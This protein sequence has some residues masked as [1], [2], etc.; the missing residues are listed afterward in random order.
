MINLSR[1]FP[2]LLASSIVAVSTAGATETPSVVEK[3]PLR[4]ALVESKDKNKGV[5]V[6]AKGSTIALVVTAIDDRYVMGRNQQ[7]TRIVIRI[8]N[9]DGVAG[10]F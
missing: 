6:Y 2:L 9:I 3:D 10:A 4:A 8:D 1:L 7:A 5:T